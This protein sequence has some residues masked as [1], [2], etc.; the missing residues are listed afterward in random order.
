MTV[1]ELIEKL[2]K[3][4]PTDEVYFTSFGV[5]VAGVW[6]EHNGHV[7]LQNDMLADGA[8]GTDNEKYLL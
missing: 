3:A 2:S 8:K 5:D 4:D 7:E 6:C 1:K